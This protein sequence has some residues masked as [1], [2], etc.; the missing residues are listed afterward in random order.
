MK[1]GLLKHFADFPAAE[2]E[3]IARIKE[4]LQNIGYEVA[5]LNLRQNTKLEDL[6][7]FEQ[8]LDYA[9][10]IHFEY[11]KFTFCTSV[12]FLWT[13]F[14]YLSWLDSSKVWPNQISHDYLVSTGDSTIQAIANEWRQM[15]SKTILRSSDYPINHTLPASFAKKPEE[16]III[17]SP[18][19]F[20]AGVNWDRLF[21]RPNRH[22]RALKELDKNNLLDT[23][24]PEKMGD[25]RPWDSFVNYKGSVPFDGKSIIGLAEKCGVYLVWNGEEHIKENIMSNRLFEALASGCL[26]IA[27]DHPFTRGVLGDLAFYLD[28][29]GSSEYFIEEVQKI[30]TWAKENPLEALNRRRILNNIYWNN[31][32]MEDQIKNYLGSI[33]SNFM[34]LNESLTIIVIGS[35]DEFLHRNPWISDKQKIIGVEEVT[36][37]TQVQ[38]LS[39]LL[40][41]VIYQIETRSAV[42]F[43]DATQLMKNFFEVSQASPE[44]FCRVKHL[45]GS[46]LSLDGDNLSPFIVESEH[47][48]HEVLDGILIDDIPI[49]LSPSLAI[50]EIE[51]GFNLKNVEVRASWRLEKAKDLIYLSDRRGNVVLK[52]ED[53]RNIVATR[54]EVVYSEAIKQAFGYKAADSIVEKITMLTRAERR[55][56]FMMLLAPLIPYNIRKFLKKYLRFFD[57]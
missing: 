30:L 44:T 56:I 29:N 34:K 53:A 51:N 37:K 4:S 2:H 54:E 42:F 18:K 52:L 26:V 8:D 13:P 38:E 39:F 17:K 3:S 57:V 15:S 32:Q 16:L 11:P 14:S 25:Y 40:S 31:Y 1:I 23:Y 9:F 21:A 6:F 19:C 22:Y 55:Y 47:W 27:D 46:C 33:P 36:K 28:P 12:G 43:S 10:D 24:G 35:I 20:Y 50:R 49:H 5:V 7:K 45:T 48:G 41:K